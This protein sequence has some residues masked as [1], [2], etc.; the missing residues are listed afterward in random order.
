M[1]HQYTVLEDECDAYPV[2][3]VT[4]DSS[5]VSCRKKKSRIYRTHAETVYS[6]AALHAE[7]FVED[8]HAHL[9]PDLTTAV[10]SCMPLKN[11]TC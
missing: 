9:Q 1:G 7:H 2:C 5:K 8:S 4:E 11:S 10:V 6:H 3:L